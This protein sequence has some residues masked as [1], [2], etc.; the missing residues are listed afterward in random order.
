M[1]I[2]V[3]GAFVGGWMCRA[4]HIASPFSG[5]VGTIFIAFIGAVVLLLLLRVVRRARV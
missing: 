2:G 5:V 3:L 1:V 4:F